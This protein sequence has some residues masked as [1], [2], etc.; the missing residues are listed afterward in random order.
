VAARL[1]APTEASSTVASEEEI[2]GSFEEGMWR[3]EMSERKLLV[4]LPE[5]PTVD[6]DI[7]NKS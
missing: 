5:A 6:L 1:A 3:C 7:K 4:S 2:G